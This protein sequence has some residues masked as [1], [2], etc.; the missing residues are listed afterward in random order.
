MSPVFSELLR[1]AEKVPHDENY[2]RQIIE[3]MTHQSKMLASQTA[4]ITDLR[5]EQKYIL[6]ALKMQSESLKTQ[7]QTV[8]AQHI[9]IVA[10]AER[11]EALERKQELYIQTIRSQAEEIQNLRNL[12]AMKTEKVDQ[13]KLTGTGQYSTF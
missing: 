13:E 4:E 5:S 11:I 2:L 10:Q 7:E 3:L 12:Q 8:Q 6:H 1:N 9:D